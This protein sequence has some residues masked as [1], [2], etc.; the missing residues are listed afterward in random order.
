[1]PAITSKGFSE[2]VEQQG[3]D[4]FHR[5]DTAMFPPVLDAQSQITPLVLS[6]EKIG[7]VRVES[8]IAGEITTDQHIRGGAT[9]YDTG[10]GFWLGDDGGTYKFFIGASAGNKMTWNGTVLA[11]TGSIT[12]TTGTIGGWTIAATQLSSGSVIINSANEQILL[13]SATAPLTGVG[14][15]LG[16]NAPVYE[17]RAGDPAGAYIHWNGSALNVKGPILT[18]LGAG[19]EV[20]IQDWT[21]SG[22][23][24]VTDLDTVAWAG[25]TLTL[26]NGSTFTITGANTGNMSAFNYIYLDISVSTTAFQVSISF[27]SGSGKLLIATAQNGTSEASYLMMGG[28]GDYNLDGGN[29]AAASIIA[30]KIS[31]ASLSAISADM[32]T[33]TA[34]TVTGATIQTASSGQRLV[35]NTTGLKGYDSSGATIIDFNTTA[36]T[37]V[38]ISKATT[39]QVANCLF[40]GDSSTDNQSTF[41]INNGGAGATKDVIFIEKTGGSTIRDILSMEVSTPGAGTN[42]VGSMIKMDLQTTTA[43]TYGINMTLSGGNISQ[44]MR[45]V[46]SAGTVSSNMFLLQS[47]PGGTANAPLMYIN[48]LGASN[49]SSLVLQNGSS[50][51]DDTFWS[52]SNDGSFSPVHAQQTDPVS[53]NYYRVS[54]FTGGGTALSM[55]VANNVSPNGTLSGSAGD[56]CLSSNGNI[57]RCTGT[58]AWSAM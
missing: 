58:T 8:L 41:A 51:N 43:A 39:G 12:A 30:S 19:S 47:G 27:T 52:I 50:A 23:F 26:M 29:I 55:W 53:T 36:G 46:H 56:I 33:I 22:A 4:R 37:I 31:V 25:G 34:G 48:N 35:M 11:I 28:S 44:G 38:A 18:D 2:S 24:S 13:G 3:F 49:V 32:G 40:I 5:K 14:I 45:I 42:T 54:K 6:E 9:A 16:L 17:F 57:Y 10:T 7:S 21:Y 1:M 20:A 15:F